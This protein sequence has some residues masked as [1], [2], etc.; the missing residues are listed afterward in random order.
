MSLWDRTNWQEGFPFSPTWL[1][2]KGS[3]RPG[4]ASEAVT[5]ARIPEDGT[6]P[7][8]WAPPGLRPIP[9]ATPQRFAPRR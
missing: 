8:P 1:K 7:V 2:P 6:P 4:T 5:A 9:G 3:D